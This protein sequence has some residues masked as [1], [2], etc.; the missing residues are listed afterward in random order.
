MNEPETF[1]FG[2][3][4]VTSVK[5][6]ILKADALERYCSDKFVGLITEYPFSFILTR[7]I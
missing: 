2:P 5:G 7:V 1:N 3:W 6:T 4:K